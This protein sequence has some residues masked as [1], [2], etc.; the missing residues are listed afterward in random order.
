MPVFQ[1][2]ACAAG[3][4]EY[5]F[6]DASGFGAG[7]DGDGGGRFDFP[8]VRPL[9]GLFCCFRQSDYCVAGCGHGV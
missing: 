4:V 6:Y 1:L 9:V 5:D 8:C 3:S 7:V 2:G